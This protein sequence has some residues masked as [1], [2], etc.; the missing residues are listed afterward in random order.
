MAL[1]TARTQVATPPCS[2]PPPDK[3]AF[4]RTVGSG[5]L[6]D[7]GKRRFYTIEEI[8]R[9]MRRLGMRADWDCWAH[10][11]FSAPDAFALAHAGIETACDHAA[12][13]SSLLSA[14]TD[15]ASDA[16]FSLDLSW[17]EWPDIGLADLFSGW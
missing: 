2:S 14:V 16:W 17:L 11:M 8:S 9:T 10:A 12:M 15:G 4:V 7:Y 6:A 1:H 5:L 3:A 13:K